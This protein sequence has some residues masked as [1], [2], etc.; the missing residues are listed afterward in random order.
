LERGL[1]GDALNR[2]VKTVQRSSLEG[3]LIAE[4]NLARFIR[5]IT[6]YLSTQGNDLLVGLKAYQKE[7]A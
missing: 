2:L 4:I 1:S 6:E 3:H 5:G 7:I